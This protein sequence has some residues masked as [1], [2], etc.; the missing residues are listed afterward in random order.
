MVREQ[1]CDTMI[2]EYFL[3]MLLLFVL[4]YDREAGKTVLFNQGQ[5][6]SR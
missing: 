3:K 4:V 1:V 5:T 6:L 2:T